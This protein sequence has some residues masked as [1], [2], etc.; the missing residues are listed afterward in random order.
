QHRVHD[1]VAACNRTREER[2]RGADDEGQR[3][4]WTD[5]DQPA[6]ELDREP[7][8]D[9]RTDQAD[10]ESVQRI[11]DHQFREQTVFGAAYVTN[12]LVARIALR[13][14]FGLARRPHQG[15]ARE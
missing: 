11:G 6:L 3:N 15:E 4:A 7:V 2:A 12:R 8:R 9:Q 13:K 1:A 10:A 5:V 14:Y